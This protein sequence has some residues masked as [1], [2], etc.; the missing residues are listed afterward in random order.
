[1]GGD[2]KGIT[3]KIKEGYFGKLGVDA[4]WMSPLVE[5]ITSE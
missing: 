5:N 2:I 3:E 1:M 4:I